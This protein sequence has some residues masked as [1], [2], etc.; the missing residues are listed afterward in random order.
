MP[1][2]APEGLYIAILIGQSIKVTSSGPHF[3]QDKGKNIT[4][5]K[6]S[7]TKRNKSI[8]PDKMEENKYN[9]QQHK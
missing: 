6:Q 9:K 1:A 5:T 3:S 7:N 4:R 8:E 2:L